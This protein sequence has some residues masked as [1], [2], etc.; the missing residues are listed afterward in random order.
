MFYNR[1]SFMTVHKLVSY[2]I[3]VMMIVMVVCIVWQYQSIMGSDSTVSIDPIQGVVTT[4]CENGKLI[5][6]TQYTTAV[7]GD[8]K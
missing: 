3:A 5:R 4:K 8:C 7:M 1:N 6:T 2:F